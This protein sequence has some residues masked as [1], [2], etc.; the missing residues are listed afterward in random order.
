[1]ARKAKKI[2]H[3]TGRVLD[4]KSEQGVPNLRVEAWDKDAIIDDF[5]GSD[6]TGERGVFEI[7]F[8]QSHFRELFSDK[9][10]DLYFK[11]FSDDKLIKSTEKSV[12]WNVKNPETEIVIE[13]NMPAEKPEPDGKPQPFKVAGL[14]RR[15][16]GAPLV[17]TLVRAF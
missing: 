8:D 14:V 16:D 5:V 13:V 7:K 17:G 15:F 1:M 3:I 4:R 12:L 9:Q 11:V 2:F 6:V 10:P